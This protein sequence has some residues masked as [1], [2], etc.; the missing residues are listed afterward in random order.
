[1]E[2]DGKTAQLCIEGNQ[3]EFDRRLDDAKALFR[4]AW[5]VAKDDYDKAIAAHYI[6]HLE[7]D[8]T[9]IH[10]WNLI[11]LKHAE[12]DH[13]AEIF[14]GSLYVNLGSSFENLGNFTEAEHHYTLAAEYG[15]IH[16][17]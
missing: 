9:K 2:I 15:V 13:R 6:A 17:R 12:R 10:E 5:E 7:Q 1:M 11:A 8:T 14:L 3:A 16:S 4:E